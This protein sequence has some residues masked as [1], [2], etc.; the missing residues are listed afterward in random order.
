[1]TAKL[2]LLP[3]HHNKTDNENI[4]DDEK[5]KTKNNLNIL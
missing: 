3:T 5:K 4:D 1:M 2:Q